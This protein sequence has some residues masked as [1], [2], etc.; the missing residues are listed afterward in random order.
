R[1]WFECFQSGDFD[2]HDQPR[3][4]RSQK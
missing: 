2:L 3:P 1:A 4:D